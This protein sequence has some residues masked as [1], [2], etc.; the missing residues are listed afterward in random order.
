MS[1]PWHRPEHPTDLAT[2]TAGLSP[3][4]VRRLEASARAIRDGAL[5]TA[6]EQLAAVLG[7]APEHPEALRL[8]GIL[9]T[10]ARRPDQAREALFHALQSWPDD[11]LALTD[12]GN[13]EQAAG[14]IETALVYWRR[15]CALA[16]DYAMGWF[17]LG[18]NLQVLG[19]TEPA[20]EALAQ[21]CGLDAALWPAHVLLGDALVHLGRFDEADRSY[22]ASLAVHPGCG[23]AWRGLAN[24]KTRPL[25]EADREALAAQLKRTDLAE[26]DR[27]AIGFALGKVNEDQG[28]HAEAFAALAEANARQRRLAPWNA[29]AFHAYVEAVV[30][31]GTSLPVAPD[32]TVGEEAIFIVGLP[33][34]GSTLFEQILAAHP[35]V[36]GASELP[37]LGE[38]LAEESAR[39]GQPFP[40]WVPAAGAQDWQRLGRRYLERTARWRRRRPRFTDKLPENWLYAGVLAAMLPGARIIDVRRDALEAGWS[41]FKQQ[42]YSLPHFACTLTDIAA[43][44]RDYE[45]AMNRWQAADPAR[46]RTQRYEALLAEPEAE[47]RALL[48][49]CGLPYESACLDFHRT[50]RAVRTPSAA[51]VRQP[52]S[53]DT[54]RAERYGRLLDPLRLGLGR[55]LAP[56]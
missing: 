53:R 20:V 38:V 23:D 54:A 43:Y 22:R 41:C 34:S 17:N 48:A 30:A 39:R 50:E 8:L 44:V 35:Q 31:A 13:A 55:P 27:I 45:V 56:S 1:L 36:E 51:Q 10:R 18:R 16:P 2:R 15:A 9:H 28:R 19:V 40:R 6:Q 46:I 29:G 52:L 12:L 26:A 32:P 37:D 7:E 5:A 3:S 24:M 25:S 4:Q 11:P 33:R 47:V 42:F 49:F 21:A 14:D